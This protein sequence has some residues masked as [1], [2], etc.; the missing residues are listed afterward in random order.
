VLP[1]S[2]SLFS[3]FRLFSWDGERIPAFSHSAQTCRVRP[4]H[5]ASSARNPFP[6]LLCTPIFSRPPAGVVLPAAVLGL[7]H[8]TNGSLP[9]LWKH[10]DPRL[11][12]LCFHKFSPVQKF[13]TRTTLPFS[14]RAD[15]SVLVEGLFCPCVVLFFLTESPLVPATGCLPAE[16]S[17]RPAV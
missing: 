13:V 10:V 15:S 16:V 12:F 1:T 8:G 3:S 17:T 9:L 2:S 5:F 4:Q 6:F 14:L 7:S 11:F